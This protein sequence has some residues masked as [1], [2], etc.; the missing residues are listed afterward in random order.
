MN[1]VGLRLPVHLAWRFWHPA[2]GELRFDQHLAGELPARPSTSCF[3]V[4]RLG[5]CNMSGLTISNS[6]H[7]QIHLG[8]H[9]PRDQV[10]PL[11]SFFGGPVGNFRTSIRTRENVPKSLIPLV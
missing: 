3:E 10:N 7:V 1:S 11:I 9:N 8:C 4:N 2:T 6:V 5:C